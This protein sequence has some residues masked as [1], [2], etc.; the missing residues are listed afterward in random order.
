MLY[1]NTK[2]KVKVH[3]PDGDTDYLDI[4]AGVLQGDTLATYLFIICLDYVLRTSTA[5]MKD[6]RFKLAKK[7]RYLAQIIT[8]ANYADDKA[9]LANTP[10]Q[11]ETHLHGLERAAGDIDVHVNADKME[12]VCFNQRGDISTRKGRSLKLV[13]NFTYLRTNVSST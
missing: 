4:V 13:E 1:K 10:T 12:Y 5:I 6:S 2:V 9:L 7:R 8:H 3:T 11:T